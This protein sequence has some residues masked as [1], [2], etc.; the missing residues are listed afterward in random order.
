MSKPFL[1][2]RRAK[3]HGR[4]AKALF[5]VG[6]A[7]RDAQTRDIGHVEA[8][9]ADGWMD[10][11]WLGGG[12]EWIHERALVWAPDVQ[13]RRCIIEVISISL[14]VPTE[15]SESGITVCVS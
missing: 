1:P 14:Q 15:P 13:P 12:R 2:G 3:A 11:L 5:T 4:T 10:V 8:V 9:R 6:D 7:V